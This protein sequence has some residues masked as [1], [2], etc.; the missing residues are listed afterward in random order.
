MVGC[1]GGQWRESSSQS[2]ED[3]ETKDRGRPGWG[4]RLTTVFKAAIG[5]R[6]ARVTSQFKAGKRENLLLSK[7]LHFLH[8]GL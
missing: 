1:T 4:A 8:P 5:W 2:G 6:D 7:G 3:Q